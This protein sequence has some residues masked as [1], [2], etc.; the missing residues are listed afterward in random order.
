MRHEYAVLQKFRHM[1][2]N[3]TKLR[4]AVDHVV[5]DASKFPN[6]R[7]NRLPGVHKRVERTNN[8]GT[9][10]QGDS[11]FHYSIIFTMS[12]GRF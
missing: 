5:S 1:F 9:V 12:A 10:H 8:F 4:L 11:D 2:C 7:C 6:K 3:L